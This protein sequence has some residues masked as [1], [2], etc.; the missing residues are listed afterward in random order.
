MTENNKTDLRPQSPISWYP[1]HMAKTK[2]LIGEN[3]NNIDAVVE[4]I[5][6]RTP[7]SSRVYKLEEI[8][9]KPRL[10]VMTKEDL[11]DKKETL[12]WIKAYQK[13]GIRVILTNL[14]DN[15][16]I[17]SIVTNELK[18]LL[19]DKHDKLVSKGYQIPKIKALIIGVPNSGKST[20][21]NKLV[22][23]NVVNT[24]NKPGVTKQLSWIRINDELDLLDSPGLL[25]PKLDQGQAMNL[26]ATSIIKEEILP[27]DEVA[28]YI[29]EFLFKYYP[30]KLEQRYGINEFNL[31]NL[32]EIYDKIGI[33]RGCLL[34]GNEIDYDRVI[35]IIIN[36]VKL[37]Y[38][39]EITFDRYKGE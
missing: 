33:R 20:L 10:I 26:A 37:G 21:I 3:I 13:E 32:V 14:M 11:C 17:T 4:V 38:L 24:G 36:D 31:D 16:N 8:I 9:N 12:K 29:L 5:D 30:V 18:V 1:G 34:K 25:A 6:A 28:T 19:S 2:R 22:G 27:L 15:N 7:F 35:N 39:N 23:K